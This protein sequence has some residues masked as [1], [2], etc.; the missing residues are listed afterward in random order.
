V[1]AGRLVVVV[2]V[3]DVKDAK[4]P[5]KSYT[6]TWFDM[7]RSKDGKADEIGTRRRGGNDSCRAPHSACA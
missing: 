6:T 7:W 3:H 4:D 5:S 2:Y 1:V